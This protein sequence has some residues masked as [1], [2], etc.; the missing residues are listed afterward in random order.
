LLDEWGNCRDA[1]RDSDGLNELPPFDFISHFGSSHLIQGY[2]SLRKA[3]S[4]GR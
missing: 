3:A 2:K 1:G 4:A